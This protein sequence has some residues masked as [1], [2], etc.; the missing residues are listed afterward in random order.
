MPA[1][2]DVGMQPGTRRPKRAD[3]AH[4]NAARTGADH[5]AGQA[6]LVDALRAAAA[7][8]QGELDV[9]SYRRFRDRDP[10]RWPSVKVLEQAFG[11]FAAALAEAGVG[12][13]SPA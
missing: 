10:G 9:T 5:P 1:S 12:P 2:F 8:V 4:T 6:E 3:A 11:S 7:T 13:A